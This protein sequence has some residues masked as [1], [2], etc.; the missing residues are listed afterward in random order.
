MAK[1]HCDKLTDGL[2]DSEGVAEFEDAKGRRHFI[3][4]ER[5]FLWNDGGTYFL[6]VV[7]VDTDSTSGQVLIELPHE[8]ETGANRLWVRPEQLDVVA[9]AFA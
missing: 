5:D 9:E 1:L 2:R 3:R 4:V 7:V 8:A 6:P